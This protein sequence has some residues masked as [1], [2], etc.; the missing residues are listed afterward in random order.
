[1]CMIVKI[2]SV[3]TTTFET[4]FDRAV[5]P[6]TLFD[7]AHPL[8]VFEPVLPKAISKRWEEHW[9]YIFSMKLFGVVPLGEQTIYI[10]EINKEEGKICSKEK[11]GLADKWNHTVF[12]EDIGEGRVKYTDNID[13]HTTF[14]LTPFVWVFTQCFYRY[15]QMKWRKLLQ[16]ST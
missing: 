10:E 11:S 2:S 5:L 13:I 15:R 16:T 9:E 3:F 4:V 12:I 6:K 1:M 7:I 8:L 14:L